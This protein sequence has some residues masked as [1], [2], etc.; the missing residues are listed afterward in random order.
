MRGG[1]L[2]GLQL[3]QGRSGRRHGQGRMARGL[4]REPLDP[5]RRPCAGGPGLVPR[6]APGRAESPGPQ[7]ALG[8]CPA[9]RCAVPRRGHLLE[10]A[11][12]SFRRRR[13]AHRDRDPRGARRAAV[14]GGADPRQG[15]HR[16]RPLHALRRHLGRALAQ[17]WIQGGRRQGAD[18]RDPGVAPPAPVRLR[19]HRAGRR[20]D[21]RLGHVRHRG[22]RDRRPAQSGPIAA[23]R[24]RAAGHLRRR[25][26]GTH[27]RGQQPAHAAG[28]LLR[29]RPRR[30]RHPHGPGQRRARRRRRLHGVPA[31]RHR[32]PRR[33]R[34]SPRPRHRQ[35]RPTGGA[36]ATRKSC[37]RSI[38][39]SARP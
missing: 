25:R 22:R 12:L 32:R 23:L 9:A 13:R 37:S 1:P 26:L 19:R 33:P 6:T 10:I 14:A 24:L 31:V 7:G 38:A 34:G 27:A 4:A 3:A 30:R 36:S 29:Q 15:T 17:A 8:R 35:S 18:A 5:R 11:H 21:V 16:A 39:P 20:S 28:P 2:Q